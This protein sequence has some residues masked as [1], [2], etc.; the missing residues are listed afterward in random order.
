MTN[1]IANAKATG[2]VRKILPAMSGASSN[3]V[4]NTRTTSVNNE[5]TSP[6]MATTPLDAAE[7]G[8]MEK[9]F[10]DLKTSIVEKCQSSKNF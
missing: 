8:A 4:S 7:F 2:A 9:K 10:T 1:M 5:V 3:F 6:T